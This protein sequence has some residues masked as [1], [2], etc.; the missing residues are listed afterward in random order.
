L[1]SLARTIPGSIGRGD[2]AGLTDW[3][4]GWTARKL[5]ASDKTGVILD[6]LADKVLLVVVFR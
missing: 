4:D 5:K 1:A 3:F 6:P 2:L